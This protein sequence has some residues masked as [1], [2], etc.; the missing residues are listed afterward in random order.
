MAG[1]AKFAIASTI[2][3][4]LGV[5]V[6]V[7]PE[8]ARSMA[9]YAPEFAALETSGVVMT[10]LLILCAQTA[11]V[12]VWR[13]V[14]LAA[15]NLVFEEAAFVWVDVILGCLIAAVLLVIAGVGVIGDA[16][17]GGPAVLLGGFVA[18]VCIVAVACVVA[19]ARGLLRAAVD[20]R[21]EMARVV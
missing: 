18:V 14:T 13:L 6:V 21:V 15:R 2:A 7:V 20:M 5:Q 1:A 3:V 19:V 10:G 8:F 9:T 4:L 11:L 17:A 12:C 16:G